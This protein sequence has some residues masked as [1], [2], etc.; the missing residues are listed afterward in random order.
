MLALFMATHSTVSVGPSS[1][2]IWKM[3]LSRLREEPMSL[4]SS[5][6]M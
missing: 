6:P 5:E 2:K 4:M 1:A 3:C